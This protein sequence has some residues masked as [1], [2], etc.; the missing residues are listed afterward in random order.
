MERVL[1]KRKTQKVSEKRLEKQQCDLELYIIKYQTAIKSG[2]KF[3]INDT[4]EQICSLYDPIHYSNYWWK[5]YGHLYEEREDFNQEY[6]RIFCKVLNEW[7]PREI[8]A[9]SRY[10]GKGYFQNFFYGALSHHFTNLVKSLSSNKR[11]VATR[12]PICEQWCNTLS[13]HLREHHQEL[14]WDY[15]K[16]H[17]R[18]VNTLTGCPFCKNYKTP[19]NFECAHSGET[20]NECIQNGL[21]DSIKKHLISKHSSF[22]FEHFH[23]LYPSHSTVSSKPM[24]IHYADE[25]GEDAS[26]YDVMESDNKLENLMALDLTPVQ[27]LI[28]NRVLNGSSSIKYDAALYK[29]T[30]REFQKEF[31]G[32]KTAMML[33][34]ITG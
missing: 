22:L 16:S 11:N 5:K 27:H 3:T 4:Y 26:I 9:E 18:D 24:S 13:S 34:G 7:R 29:C 17:G 1:A 10:G 15:L 25:D 31:E 12:C 32:L 33:C 2:N 6:L 23:D 20:C 28:L 8:R 19:K 30:Q 21:L 14:M